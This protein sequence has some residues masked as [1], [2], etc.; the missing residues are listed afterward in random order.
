MKTRKFITSGFNLLRIM[1][2]AV[3]IVALALV[4]ELGAQ[5]VDPSKIS[6]KHVIPPGDY[7]NIILSNKTGAGQAMPAVVFPHWWHRSQFTCKVCHTEL[8]FPMKAGETDFVMGDIFSGKQCGEC[9]NGA[10]AF[11]PMDCNRCHSHGL[12]VENNRDIEEAFKDLLLIA[13]MVTLGARVLD[14]GDVDHVDA[15]RDEC[16]LAVGRR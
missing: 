7:G 9:H 1:L 15:H 5:T 8:G 14:V 6:R 11:A 3:F 10:I 2:L 12:D 13:E 16:R 4:P